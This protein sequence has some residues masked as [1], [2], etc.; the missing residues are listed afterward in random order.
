MSWVPTG[1]LRWAQYPEDKHGWRSPP[2]LEQEFRW[3]PSDWDPEGK[4]KWV[5]VKVEEID[6]DQI[7]EDYDGCKQDR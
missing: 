2:V 1:R 6:K 7:G 4:P 5:R 3:E